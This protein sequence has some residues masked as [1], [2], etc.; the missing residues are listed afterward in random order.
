M[1]RPVGSA[2]VSA[3]QA[4]RRFMVLLGLRWGGT[5]FLLPVMVLV[6]I[7]RGFSLGDIG[8]ITA[9]QGVMVLLLELPTGGLSDALGRRPVLMMASIFGAASVG[10]YVVADSLPLLVVVFA[11]QGIYRALDS[12][13]LEAWYVDAALAADPDADIETGLARGSL[14][15]GLAMAAGSLAG[16]GLVALGPLTMG[17][18]GEV[19][20]LVLPL[21]ASLILE[22]AHLVAV[23]G[24]MTEPHRGD[25]RRPSRRAA[26]H[27][28]M[29]STPQVVSQAIGLIRGNRILL[30]VISVEFLWGFGG[31]AYETFTPARL[32]EV[33]G[34]SDSAASLL[35][36]THAV[37]W[38]LFAAG[39][40]AAPALTRW[41]GVAYAA[42][43]LRIVQ[44]LTVV[45]IAVAAGPVGVIAAFLLTLAVHGAA[46]PVHAGLLHRTVQGPT[47]RATV[48]SAN[49]MTAQTGAMLGGIA[50]GALADATTLTT[51]I[52]AGAVILA[53]A[54][55]L[56][57]P[58]RRI[59]TV[60]QLSTANE[61]TT[62]PWPSDGD[63]RP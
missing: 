23:A 40:S 14:A 2:P 20:P 9:A 52:L 41:L 56:Y 36:P 31:T 27:D 57:L 62:Q 12:G 5:G 51:A 50:L 13:P 59:P 35:G 54:A 43:A 21:F 63:I 11:L 55:P 39:V 7:E 17:P 3:G 15:L 61:V 49:S 44:G 25:P 60:A 18:L 4:R 47:H 45:G 32:A 48:V 1:R 26:L 8:L 58:A 29:R 22:V 24:L 6:M 10:L 46:N 37:A 19:D 53:A 30:A 34:D 42:A 28:A 33:V 16:G 38:L